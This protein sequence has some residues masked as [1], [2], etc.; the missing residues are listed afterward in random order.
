[1]NRGRSILNWLGLGVLALLVVG[2]IWQ[3][4]GVRP[5][6]EPKGTVSPAFF[7]LDL[8]SPLPAAMLSPVSAA[9]NSPLPEQESAPMPPLMATPIPTT[10]PADVTGL[11][12]TV[13]HTND[14]WGYL[15][16]CG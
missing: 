4:G 3:S 14:T 9:L 8:S 10:V 5:T 1:M 13:L 6:D 16:P 2:L 7:T 11:Q 12:L 15:L